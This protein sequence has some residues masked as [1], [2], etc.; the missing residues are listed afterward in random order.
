M[1]IRV[2]NGLMIYRTDMVPRVRKSLRYLEYRNN[3]SIPNPD[4]DK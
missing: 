3:E 1:D 2:P 4:N